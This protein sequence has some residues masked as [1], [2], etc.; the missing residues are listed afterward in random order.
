MASTGENTVPDDLDID[1]DL[2]NNDGDME[3][4]DDDKSDSKKNDVIDEAKED[5]GG[6]SAKPGK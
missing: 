3:K 4:Q 6:R 2:D 1:L 5:D